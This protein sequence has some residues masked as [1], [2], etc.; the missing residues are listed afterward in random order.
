MNTHKKYKD[1]LCYGLEG[2]VS[3]KCLYYTQSS[4]DRDYTESI[5]GDRIPAEF[6]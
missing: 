2:L 3:S 5:G 6:F 4:I 1:V